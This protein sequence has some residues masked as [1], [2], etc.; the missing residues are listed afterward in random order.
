MMCSRIQQLDCAVTI[1]AEAIDERK[2]C[3]ERGR[4]EGDQQ[5][6]R[7]GPPEHQQRL[8]DALCHRRLH[9]REVELGDLYG[10]DVAVTA[11][12]AAGERVVVKRF[13]RFQV[14]EGA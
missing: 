5:H 8:P 10:N 13:V 7:D 14:G 1:G 3:C 4:H 11:G 9:G 6:D 2:S 12:L